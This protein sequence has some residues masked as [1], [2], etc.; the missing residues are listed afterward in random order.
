MNEKWVELKL[1]ESEL[2]AKLLRYLNATSTVEMGDLDYDTVWIN[3]L[4]DM[5]LKLPTVDNFK[6]FVVLYSADPE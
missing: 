1:E 3:L 6:S 4:R 5:V 2:M